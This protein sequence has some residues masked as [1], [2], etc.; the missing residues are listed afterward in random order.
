MKAKSAAPS[1]G[2]ADCHFLKNQIIKGTKRQPHPAGLPYSSRTQRTDIPYRSSTSYRPIPESPPFS[3]RY[4]AF[5][6]LGE[7]DQK[8]PL[9]PPSK[10]SP[11]L[12]RRPPAKAEKPLVFVPS[13]AG[14]SEDEAFNEGPAAA[15]P[16]KP[17][18]NAVHSVSVGTC[19]PEGHNAPV[20]TAY[21]L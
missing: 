11:R 1:T 19:Q 8:Y 3:F 10:K 18:V 17:F 9:P 2:T 7:D 14:E 21:Q 4:H 20:L 15:T 13:Q 16:P 12:N 6:P 5:V